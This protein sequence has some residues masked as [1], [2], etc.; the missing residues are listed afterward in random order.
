MKNTSLAIFCGSKP[1]K[2]ILYQQHAQRLG[3]ILVENN[4][5][6]IYGGGKNELMGCVADSVMQRNG[7]WGDS[8]SFY[9]VVGCASRG[10]PGLNLVKRLAA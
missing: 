6:M 10:L 8:T 7:T 5:M 9:A 3:E 4:I 1:G 2:N